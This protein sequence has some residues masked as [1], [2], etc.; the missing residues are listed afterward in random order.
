FFFFS[1]RRRHTSFSRDWSSDVCSSDLRLREIMVQTDRRFKVIFAGLQDVQRFQ[2]L[3]NQPLA[4]FGSPQRVGPLEPRPAQ[5]LIK[6]PLEA[7][8]YRID[9]PSILRILSYTN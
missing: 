2:G 3:P 5:Q 7:V 9:G 4:H 1:S 6:E 8:G